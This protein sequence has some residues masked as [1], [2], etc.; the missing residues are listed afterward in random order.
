MPKLAA[1]P[2]AWI[3]DLCV[4]G[5]DVAARVDRPRPP[6]S[7]STGWSSTAGS[8]TCRTSPTRQRSTGGWPRT[9]GCA[10]PMLCCSPDFTHPDPAFRQKQID[11]EKAWI[12]MTAALGG[13]F[14]RVLSG[15]APAGGEP[16]G[17]APLRGRRHPGL[18][19]RTRPSAGVTLILEN[20]YKDNYWEYPEFAQKTDVFC[21]LVDRVGEHPN[22]GVNYDPSNTI[23]AG[24]DPLELLRAREAPRRHDARQRPL[25]GR[26]HDRR[27]PPG[28][29]RR[30]LRQ[31]PAATARSARG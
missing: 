15:P 9:A 12:D 7:T 16:R 30:R 24:E 27:P 6:R 3:D 26:G 5:D 2:K 19:A 18:P 14:C 20:H 25:P 11:L 23:L 22:F 4:D 29:G 28:R 13:Q 31:A 17:R 1:F 21:D 8:S 10:M